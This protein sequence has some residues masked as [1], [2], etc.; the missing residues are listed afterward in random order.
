MPEN[1]IT[2][3]V[4]FFKDRQ[5][6]MLQWR[7]PDTN[8]IKSQSA[9]THIIGVARMK[10]AVL[11]ADLNRGFHK[12]VSRM[13]WERFRELFED[14]YL[15]SKRLNTQLAYGD[16][17][18][19]F[20]EL[21]RPP[22]VSKIT[23]RTVSSFAAAL[24]RLPT[25]GRTGQKASSIKLRLQHLRTALRWAV[26]QGM[27]AKCP[28]FPKIDVPEKLPQPVPVESFER[29]YAKAEGDAMMQAY[30]LCGWLAGLRL[31]EA[32]ELEWEESE[33]APYV[34]LARSRIVLP[35]GFAKSKVDQWV[36]LDALLRETLL[37]LPRQG[38]KVFRFVKRLTG[39]PIPAGAL[40]RRVV[41]LAKRAGVRLTMH[42]LRKGFG[43]RYAGK[44]PAQVLK[45]L[46]RH[47]NIQTT[48][49][50]YVNTDAA[51]MEA[52]LGRNITTPYNKPIPAPKVEGEDDSVTG[53]GEGV[54]EIG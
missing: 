4:T 34:D 36:P 32:Y 42:T 25:R 22:A 20:A 54:G 2:V 13:S 28:K 30:L 10:A 47:K 24:G 29:I 48:L 31:S 3:W 43:C 46:M 35:A 15:A 53:E 41:R 1:E 19:K 7:D 11:Q 9:D 5:S 37:A 14:E 18:D 45:Q 50:Y 39:E 26:D 44:V 12:D 16:T 38:A 52:V 21:A 23:A 49:D 51:A 27:L 6:Y 17:L 33:E 8:K 40:S